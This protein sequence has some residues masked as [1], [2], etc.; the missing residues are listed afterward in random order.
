MKRRNF[1]QGSFQSQGLSNKKDNEKN[2]SSPKP[3]S[4]T[5]LEPYTGAWGFE[6]AAHLLRRTTFNCR[7]QDILSLVSKGMNGAVDFLFTP[8]PLPQPPIAIGTNDSVKQGETWVNAAFNST[9]DSNRLESLAGWWVNLMRDNPNSAVEKMVLFWHNHFVSAAA[10]VKDARYSYKQIATFRENVFGNFKVLTKKIALDPAM[11]RYLNGNTNTKQDTNENFARE[12]QELFTIGKGKEITKGN[13]TTYTEAD[14]QA[15]ARVL[16]GFSDSADK[17]T[18]IF[19]DRN[20]DA[21]DKVF[22]AAYGNTVIKGRTGEAGALAELDDLLTMIF[23]QEATA[24]N[25]CREIYRWYA[26]YVID[27]TIEQNI[28]KPMA[29]ILKD[30]NYELKPALLALF[31]SSHFYDSAR[32]G[33]MIKPTAD[34]VLSTFNSVLA[35]LPK[36]TSPTDY[37][38]IYYGAIGQRRVMNSMQQTLF[39]HPNV[40][41]WEAYHQE[42]NYYELW[43]NTDTLQK[44]IKYVNDLCIAGYQSPESRELAY[45][46]VFA[47]AEETSDP[48]DP[49]KL[50]QEW[51]RLLY[52]FD[53]SADFKNNLKSVFLDGLPDYEWTVEWQDYKATP[54]D[55]NK[56]AAVEKKLRSLLKQ[57]MASPEYQLM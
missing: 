28:I 12:L 13:Y 6:Q 38:R 31:K 46:D 20:H 49:D 18:Y 17:I 43:I 55:T 48:A 9:T 4:A 26:D 16:T 53:V 47:L 34:F 54:T 29:K 45:A 27:D 51:V 50:I 10:S 52:A 14:V 36:P 24:L 42:P 33:S 11:L 2:V 1:L 57:I 21:S 56:K 22:S 35:S 5:G 25:I 15:A 19:T 40:A 3:L 39:G 7:R 30:N 8:Q 41:G 37:V 23:N 32:F 44:R